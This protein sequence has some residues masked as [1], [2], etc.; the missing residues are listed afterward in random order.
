MSHQIEAEYSWRFP[1][2][3]NRL[4][5]IAQSESQPLRDDPEAE[6]I[7]EHYWGYNTQRGGSTMEYRVEHPRWRVWA[8]VSAQL[9]CDVAGLYGPQLEEASRCPPASAFLAEG[10]A[11]RVCRRVR[12]PD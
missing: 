3:Q 11:V 6:F 10:S 2:R 7:T 9:D 1:G 8:A 5:F 12:L 4:Q